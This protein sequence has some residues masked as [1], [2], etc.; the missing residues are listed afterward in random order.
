M[1]PPFFAPAAISA[2]LAILVAPDGAA[3][4]VAYVTGTVG[5]LLGAD[6]YNLRRIVRMDAAVASIGGAGT[7]DG[8]FLAGLLASLLAF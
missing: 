1:A 8:I 4:P 2:L 5:T 6:V 3:A 7:W